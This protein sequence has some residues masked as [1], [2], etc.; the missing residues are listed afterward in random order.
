MCNTLVR[1]S[2]STT[3]HGDS[4]FTGSFWVSAKVFA[5]LEGQ[6][7]LESRLHR[8]FCSVCRRQWGDTSTR[9]RCLQCGCGMRLD[10]VKGECPANPTEG[11]REKTSH[12]EAVFTGYCWVDA[13]LWDYLV[14]R[15]ATR[16]NPNDP[17]DAEEQPEEEYFEETGIAEFGGCS[18]CGASW[19]NSYKAATCIFCGSFVGLT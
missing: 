13:G 15:E 10:G 11:Q 7:D 1:G 4:V 5:R 19:G 16:S 12:G 14:S 8:G 3:S 2:Q 9:S 17:A 18:G 6:P